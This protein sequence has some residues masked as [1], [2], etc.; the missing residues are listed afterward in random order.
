MSTARPACLGLAALALLCAA[1]RAA[2]DDAPIGPTPIPFY[3]GNLSVTR[4]MMYW[5]TS[6][7]PIGDEVTPER[8][9]LLRRIACFADCDYQAWCIA[10]PEPGRWDFSP[11]RRN[12]EALRRAGLGYVPFSW[13]HF[14]P[15]WF[16]DSPDWTPYRCGEHGEPLMQLSPWGPK[17]LD[18]YRSFYRAQHAALGDLVGWIRVGTPSDYGEVG[19]P[20]AMTSWLVPQTHAHAGYWCGDLYARADFRSEMRRRFGALGALNRRWGTAFASWDALDYPALEGDAGAAAARASGKPTDRRRWLD[21]VEWYYGA[22]LR[23]V[24]KLVGVV[25][26]SYPR[27]PLI[28]SVGYASERACYGND[29][30]ALPAMARRL[31]IALQTPGNVSYYGLKRVSTACHHYGARYYTEP[32]GDVPPEAEVARVFSDVSNGVQVYFEYPQNLDGARAQLRQYK[33]YMSG[34]RPEV[35]LALFNPTIDHR[36]EGGADSFPRTVFL[37]GETGR[38]LFDYDV[39]DEFLARDGALCRYR[40]LAW[41]GGQVT[42]GFALRAVERWVRGGG[43]LLTCR[44]GEVETVEGDRAPWRRLAPDA[45]PRI[46]EIA[47]RA[48][49]GRR[50]GRGA[51]IRVE[52]APDATAALVRAVER[53]AHHP[54]EW[55]P[56]F[57]GA[58]LI[59]GEADGVRATLLP[60]RILYHN[61]TDRPIVRRISLRAA[62]WR[63][64]PRRPAA[65]EQALKLPPHSI[66]SIALEPAPRGRGAGH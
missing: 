50:L 43:V 29:Y 13:V 63:G 52:A 62:D 38:D 24:P 65:L 60:E 59:D 5:G 27:N 30:T 58:P 53:A 1:A 49:T 36:L 6:K 22:W 20:A 31:G 33:R 46:G 18:I 39:V 44:L 40:V 8:I 25:R 64:R 15:K 7:G 61:P 14:P 12:A 32:P 16:L 21:F 42:E 55:L 23:F 48:V 47:G 56:G 57:R 9:A 11:Y 2:N 26:E 45:M 51:V 41:L 17:T 28:I 54:G 10:Q 37:V 19:Y 4:F 66:A 34:A 3:T 35:D